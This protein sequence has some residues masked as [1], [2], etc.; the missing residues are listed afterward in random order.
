MNTTPNNDNPSA[1]KQAETS[2]RPWYASVTAGRQ[3]GLVIS[4]KTGAA[5]A[6]VYLPEDRHLLAA[7]PALAEALERLLLGCEDH[8]FY[9]PEIDK[10]R[11]VLADARKG[12]AL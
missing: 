2:P 3:Q 4:E 8:D 11:A 9:G 1:G 6:L 10:A 7:A 12:G 5:V